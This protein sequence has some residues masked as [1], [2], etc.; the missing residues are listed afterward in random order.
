[1][2]LRAQSPQLLLGWSLV[3]TLHA[4]VLKLRMV[5]HRPLVPQAH[6]FPSV[7]VAT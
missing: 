4:N 3:V 5:G 2:V 6:K 1:M 7:V